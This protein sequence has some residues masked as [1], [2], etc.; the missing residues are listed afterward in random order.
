MNTKK[1]SEAM[2]K[3][4]DKYYVEAANYQ[5]E[6]KRA[7]WSAIA[8][9][10]CLA[11]IGSFVVPNMLNGNHDNPNVTPAAYP[12]VMVDGGIYLI[13]PEGYAASE[14]PDEYLEI[15]KIEGN[16]SADKAQNWYS[17]GC[18]VGEGIYQS[19]DTSEVFVYTTLFSGNSEYRYI[20]FVLFDE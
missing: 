10:L 8:A 13:D 11:I 4:D 6:R 1:F 12:Y 7:K 20:R 2:S 15:G 5:P 17:Q 16:A 18:K 14:L 9:C 3:V 19:S